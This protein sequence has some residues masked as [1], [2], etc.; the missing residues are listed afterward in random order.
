VQVSGSGGTV[1]EVERVARLWFEHPVGVAGG[2]DNSFR[3][4]LIEITGP[5]IESGKSGHFSVMK[6]QFGHL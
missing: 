2:N 5:N 3:T 6:E 4:D 1:P